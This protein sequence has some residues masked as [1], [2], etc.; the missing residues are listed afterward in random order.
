VCPLVWCRGRGCLGSQ[1]LAL[2]GGVRASKPPLG[3]SLPASRP[4]GEGRGFLKE[5]E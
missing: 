2:A 3:M 1:P 4:A 5:E